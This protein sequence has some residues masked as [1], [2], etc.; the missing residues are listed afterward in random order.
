MKQYLLFQLLGPE[1]TANQIAQAM[2][3]GRPAQQ[4]VQLGKYGSQWKKQY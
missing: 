4:E 1:S 2:Q 3:Q